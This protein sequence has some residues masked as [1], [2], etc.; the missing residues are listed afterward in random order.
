M[1][2]SEEA[3][4]FK[5]TALLSAFLH[6]GSVLMAFEGNEATNG[7][8]SSITKLDLYRGGAISFVPRPL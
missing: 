4:A 5:L 7:S 6:K 3:I 2:T 8:R 1:L